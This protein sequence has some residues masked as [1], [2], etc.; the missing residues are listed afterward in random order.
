M[1]EI[2]LVGPVGPL[3]SLRQTTANP[4]SRSSHVSLNDTG[5]PG[6]T[7]LSLAVPL[8]F[9]VPA[10]YASRLCSGIGAGPWA[11][12]TA[13][14]PSSKRAARVIVVRISCPPL[15]HLTSIDLE[16]DSRT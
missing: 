5:P 12:A 7:G 11:S 9:Q 15:P 4:P 16:V 10:K 14:G 2:A 1:M 8:K 3:P 6:P 13:P